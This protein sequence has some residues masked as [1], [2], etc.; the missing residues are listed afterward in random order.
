MKKILF[1]IMFS[2]LLTCTLVLI[3][4]V[5][6]IQAHP[7]II[8]VDDNNVAGPW[9]G[10]PDHPYKNIT[11]GL[12]HA[13]AS[14][15][16]YVYN[17]TYRE[18]VIIDKPVSITGDDK[19][20][21]II[22]G[23]KIGNVVKITASNVNVTHF[24]IQ[25]S[26]SVYEFSGIRLENSTGNNISYNIIINNYE[27]IWLENS[28]Q[29]TFVENTFSN[30]SEGI[31]LVDSSNNTFIG[32]KIS[33]N[34]FGTVLRSSVNNTFFHNSF[35]DNTWRSA[36]STLNLTNSWDD[37]VEGNYWSDYAGTDEDQDGIGDSPYVIDSSNQDNYPIMGTF[38]DFVI[39]YERETYHVLTICSSTISH[40]QYNETVKMV[41]F[42]ITNTNNSTGFCRIVIPESLGGKPYIVLMD[43]EQVNATLLPRSNVT[44][45][46]LYFE[47][48]R[49]A[50]EVRI[51]SKPYYDLLEN[52]NVLLEN[53]NSLNS[54]YYQL[55][56]DYDLL[57]QTYQETM[58]NYT[59]LLT[60]YDSLNR[61]YWE[62]FANYSQLRA[63]YDMLN[64]TYQDLL[65]QYNGLLAD[66]TDLNQSYQQVRSDYAQLQTDFNTLNQAYQETLTNYTM[67]QNDY[68]SLNATYTQTA[69]NYAELL[70]NHYSLNQ[71]YQELMVNFAQLQ[72]DRDNLLEQYNSLN[73]AYD[74]IK[75]E[76]ASTRIFLWCI[77][78]VAVAATVVA[79]SFAVKYQKRSKGQK[80]LIEEYKAELNRISRLSIARKEIET[81][82]Q[83]RRE[84]IRKFEQKYGFT[85]RTRK[86]LEDI[87]ANLLQ[88]KKKEE[89]EG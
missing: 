85:V 7:S 30:S 35:I 29:N 46:F 9:D 80:K 34:E 27:G 41:D 81:D 21:T 20:N 57:N 1:M 43:D 14:D 3:L 61:T 28:S 65:T 62:T 68:D 37:G 69:V 84:K 72:I 55:L 67:L 6:P 12:A 19:Y 73:T 17:G 39:I 79:S 40:F 53:Y 10:T 23:N 44:H 83:A 13:L 26:L 47:Y 33:N 75:S 31:Y 18:Q 15:T 8:F 88:K 36:A 5:A 4:K 86:T 2:L 11:S 24:T 49:T 89:E 32:N 51:L 87:I 59:Q 82:V 48:N 77:S 56:N 58:A 16:I 54:T 25:N 50:G 71:T 76:Y 52:Y 74:K 38:S 22:D 42:N 45:S 78:G 70:V 60:E 64:Q 66:Y 63:E